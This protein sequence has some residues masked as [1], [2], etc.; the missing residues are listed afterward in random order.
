MGDALER[1]PTTFMTDDSGH[2]SSM[3]L[4]S[5]LALV[6]AAVLA[7]VSVFGWGSGSGN[8]ELVLYFLV[9]VFGPKAVQ[10]FAE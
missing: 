4:M 10:K 9:A 3:R 6:T 8:T 2:P 1:K 5:V 7:F